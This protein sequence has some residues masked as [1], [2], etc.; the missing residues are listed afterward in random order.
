MGYREAIRA[1]LAENGEP[2]KSSGYFY[3]END[4]AQSHVLNDW[5]DCGWL[6]SQASAA[7]RSPSS[8]SRN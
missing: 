3:I 6:R 1:F 7:L 2:V 8:R 4:A 5:P